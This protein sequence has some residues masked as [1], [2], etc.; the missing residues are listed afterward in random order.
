MK[1][2]H[3]VMDTSDPGTGKTFV[4]IIDFAN[5]RKKGGGCALVVAPRSILRSVWVNDFKKFA[6]NII[7]SVADAKHRSTAMAAD[8]D[9]YIVNID[10]VKDLEKLKPAFW[11]KFD[12]LI[13]DEIT[14]YKHH[15]S[16]RS[17]AITHL[18][19]HFKWRRGLT[20]TPNAN[21]LL[22]VWSPMYLIDDGQRLGISFAQFR[23]STCDRKPTGASGARLD[24]VPRA[25]SAAIVT[26]LMQDITIRHRLE[27]CVDMPPYHEY[28]REL[29]LSSKLRDVY[30][31]MVEQSI[32]MYRKRKI[33]AVNAA[34][35][36][37]KLLQIASGAVFDVDK[38]PVQIDSERVELALDLVEEAPQAL[39]FY[40]WHHQRDA[41]VAEATKRGIVHAVIDSRK[42]PEEL[43]RHFQGGLYQILFAHP[44][45]A[46]HGLT[47]TKA[48]RAIWA[49][50]TYNLEYRIQGNRRIYRIGQTQRTESITLLAKDTVDFVAHDSSDE[51]DSNMGAF[52]RFLEERA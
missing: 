47:L 38:N 26:A 52:L 19:R 36:Y 41:L 45:A 17:R 21:G 1:S 25:S 20:G 13:I 43:V 42:D 39:V 27:A 7:C 49:S 32:I 50:P 12:T 14:K 10:G 22:D 11:R 48:T 24:W 3:R 16:A 28:T 51:K 30:D 31:E 5:R 44:D 34:V 18:K 15:T 35:M 2:K 9:V 40:M 37:G 46:A 23:N 4:Q 8:A 6:P 33:T 29:E